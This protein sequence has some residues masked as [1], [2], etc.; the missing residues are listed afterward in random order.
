MILV[1]GLGWTT[2]L[3][4]YVAKRESVAKVTINR[5]LDR[6]VECDNTIN[7]KNNID[8]D[9][10]NTTTVVDSEK[11]ENNTNVNKVK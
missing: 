3:T 5:N 6:I 4:K 11:N 2:Y 7:S 1:S 10:I 8:D 9:D